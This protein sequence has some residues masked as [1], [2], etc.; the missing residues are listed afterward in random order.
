MAFNDARS[1]FKA[2]QKAEAPDFNRR[3]IHYEMSIC[4]QSN[5]QST[6][7]TPV[8]I[9]RSR[10]DMVQ[11]KLDVRD[12]IFD[13]ENINFSNVPGNYYQMYTDKGVA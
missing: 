7:C 6:F 2:S 12:T 10:R 5:G 9:S 11:K 8:F 3:N 4:H 1:A 13:K